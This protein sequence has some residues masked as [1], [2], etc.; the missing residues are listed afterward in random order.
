[1]IASFVLALGAATQFA[2]GDARDLALCLQQASQRPVAVS[3]LSKRDFRPFTFDMSESYGFAKTLKEATDISQT[4]GVHMAFSDRLL[5]RSF[6]EVDPIYQASTASPF[7]AFEVAQSVSNGEVTL[8][9]PKGGALDRNLLGRINF[10][11]ALDVHWTVD[12]VS[13]PVFV[14]K[15]PERDFL[16]LVGKAT[17]TVLSNTKDRYRLELDP[18]E[19]RFRANNT[20]KKF[21][22]E[23][24]LKR[25]TDAQ[26]WTIEMAQFAVGIADNESLKRAFAS[27]GSSATIVLGASGKQQL[28]AAL[29]RFAQQ[30]TSMLS[31]AERRP[32]G[33]EQRVN[34]PGVGSSGSEARVPVFV[35]QVNWNM[36]VALVL[37]SNFNVRVLAFSGPRGRNSRQVSLDFGRG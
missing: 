24:E 33:A 34:A 2:G 4:P 13:I 32:R 23:A 1:M 18:T 21:G 28:Y 19:F 36:D 37:R 12:H 7:S 27:R 11:K 22:G 9:T 26:R 25:L 6:I 14:D 30:A 31:T 17:G 10:T 8:Q 5:P 15:M 20:F 3:V 29:S 16:I 35:S